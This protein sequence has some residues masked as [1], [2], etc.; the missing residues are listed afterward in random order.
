MLTT[1]QFEFFRSHIKIDNSDSTQPHN[2]KTQL[3]SFTQKEDRKASH[4]IRKMV[5]FILG[6]QNPSN[7]DDVKF[8]LIDEQEYESYDLKSNYEFKAF[9]LALSMNRSLAYHN[10]GEKINKNIIS[11]CHIPMRNPS[12]PNYIKIENNY[13]EKFIYADRKSIE[14]FVT[15]LSF[16]KNKFNLIN[17]SRSSLIENQIFF[18]YFK[19]S[20]YIFI[21]KISDTN[22]S[23]NLL[24]N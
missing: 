14:K 9:C 19:L 21:K 18:L 22:Y 8:L 20:F 1:F 10:L 17:K 16:L 24:E 5:N 6:K 4:L 7:C 13:T 15:N 3:T 11:H 23:F 2:I 12:I